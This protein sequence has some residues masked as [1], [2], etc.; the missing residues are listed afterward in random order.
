MKRGREGRESKTTADQLA[1]V[2]KARLF[3]RAGI[4]SQE[5]MRNIEKAIRIQ[6]GMQ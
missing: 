1:T 2:G 4:I 6:L 5:E 3:R